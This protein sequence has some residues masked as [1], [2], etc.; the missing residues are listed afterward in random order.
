[1]VGEIYIDMGGDEV[2]CTVRVV[3]SEEAGN[4]LEAQ[5]KTDLGSTTHTV[6]NRHSCLPPS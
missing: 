5:E 2:Y 1:M 6:N 3:P 4:D